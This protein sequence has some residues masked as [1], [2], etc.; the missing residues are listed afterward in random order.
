[1]SVIV[2]PSS[3]PAPQ[4]MEFAQVDACSMVRSPFTGQAQVFHWGGVSGGTWL[5]V[6]VSL[7]PLTVAQAQQWVAFFRA[8]RGQANTFQF[9]AAFVAAYPWLLDSSWF[10][11]LKSNTRKWSLTNQ[12]VFGVQFE[13][14][15]VI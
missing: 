4:S 11:R 5:E 6:S 12:R 10:W 8:L 2:I 15:Q 7:P 3:P 9:S 13:A 1:M 14:I